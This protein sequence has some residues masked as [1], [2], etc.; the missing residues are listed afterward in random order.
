MRQQRL[1]V[2]AVNVMIDELI[3]ASGGELKRERIMLL[4]AAGN[5]VMELLFLGLDVTSLGASPFEPVVTSFKPTNANSLGLTLPQNAIVMT[6]PLIG[7]FIGGD[8][9]AGV[10]S[11]ET[12]LKQF[13]PSL[14][15]DIGTNGEMV[16]ACEDGRLLATST[17]AG[18]ALEGSGIEQGMIAAR[19]AIEKVWQNEDGS[20][21]ANVIGNVKPIG[22]C[23][24]GL[25]D[26]IALL[27]D[28]GKL[29]S[30][31]KMSEKRIELFPSSKSGRNEPIVITQSDVRQVQL[32]V[33]AIRAGMELLLNEA[34]YKLQDLKQ[35]LLAGGFGNYIHKQTAQRIGLLPTEPNIIP[36]KNTSL[37]GAIKML[38]ETEAV[39]K[40]QS[41]A[42]RTK[43]ID[44]S[45]NKNFAQTFANAMMFPDK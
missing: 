14:L 2:E 17:A 40:S 38:C 28:N 23:G 6:I 25:V 37:S 36:V 24:S 13:S 1:L 41:I 20:Y 32:A 27:L 11:G 44:L 4:T 33:G 15:L 5:S 21:G 12:L 35:L 30:T 43:H 29:K 42:A 19:G 16:L 18:P 10:V 34:G 45:R 31:G 26:V 3:A 7:G 8:I 39:T 9:T 22:I